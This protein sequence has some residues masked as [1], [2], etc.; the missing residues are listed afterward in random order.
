MAAGAGTAAAVLGVAAHPVNIL[1]ELMDIWTV[2]TVPGAGAE[3]G[4]NF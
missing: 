2:V 4:F 1:D 3:E